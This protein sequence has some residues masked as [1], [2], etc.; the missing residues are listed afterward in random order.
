MVPAQ[1]EEV[2]K[3]EDGQ[4]QQPVASKKSLVE[5][6]TTKPQSDSKQSVNPTTEN[7]ANDQTPEVIKTASVTGKYSDIKLDLYFFT[8]LIFMWYCR[9]NTSTRKRT[10]P[11]YRRNPVKY[12]VS[13]LN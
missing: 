12:Y 9:R 6:E 5:A 10:F 13:T 4:I 2:T 11:K 7:Q 8:L 3:E 1:E